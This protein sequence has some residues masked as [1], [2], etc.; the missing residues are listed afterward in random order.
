MS[1]MRRGLGPHA[2][3][4]KQM[5]ADG[6]LDKHGKTTASTPTT[7]TSSYVDYSGNKGNDATLMN[8][9][10]STKSTT[11]TTTAATSDSKKRMLPV[12]S[13]N[14][15][16]DDDAAADGDDDNNNNNNNNNKNISSEP[17]TKKVKVESHKDTRL[18]CGACLNLCV[19]VN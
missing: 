4:K 13:N 16:D 2:K 17:T 7:W 3:L 5:I 15:D 6:L 11:T 10:A 8:E 1:V 19:C 14:N 18:V 9:I 12:S